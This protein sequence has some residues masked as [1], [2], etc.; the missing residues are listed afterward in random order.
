MLEQIMNFYIVSLAISFVF[1]IVWMVVRDVEGKQVK[2]KREFNNILFRM[3]TGTFCHYAVL[4]G[5]I[6][7][8]KGIKNYYR[9]L[10]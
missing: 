6:L 5:I 2:T 3:L 9:N 10:E 1:F 8:Y 4:K 7:A